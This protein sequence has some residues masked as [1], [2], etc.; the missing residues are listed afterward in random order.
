MFEFKNIDFLTD[1]EIDLRINKK[2]PADNQKGYVPAY[3][4]DIYLNNTN[5]KVGGICL[6]IGYNENIYYA[7]NIG[8]GVDEEFRGHNYA[9]KACKL[10]KQVAIAHDM[11]KI[12]ITCNPDNL[13]SRRTCEKLLLNLLEIADLPKDNEMYLEGENQKCIF[14]WDL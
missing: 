11:K 3:E 9:M 13:P 4:Y 10:V 1:V 12:Y 6:R 2:T 8:Y 5:I 7:G 14:E